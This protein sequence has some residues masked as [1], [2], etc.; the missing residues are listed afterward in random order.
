MKALKIAFSL[1]AVVILLPLQG[2]LLYT[3]LAAIHPDRLIWF[4]F[5][6]YMATEFLLMALAPSNREAQKGRE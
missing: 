5:W 2:F 1:I 6:I 3:I 4:L